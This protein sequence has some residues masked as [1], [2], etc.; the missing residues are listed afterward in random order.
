MNL[1]NGYRNGFS[2]ESNSKVSRALQK[3][4]KSVISILATVVRIA[5]QL[6]ASC[7]KKL[8]EIVFVMLKDIDKDIN[9]N[10]EMFDT[11]LKSIL[12]NMG[13]AVRNSSC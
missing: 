1:A 10:G 5:R 8:I 7:L 13:D 2:L 11:L 4:K 6:I 3:N 9:K 12:K